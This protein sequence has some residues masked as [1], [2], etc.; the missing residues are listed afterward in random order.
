MSKWICSH[1]S[2]GKV[3]RQ[4]SL[5]VKEKGPQFNHF[6]HNLIQPLLNLEQISIWHVQYH[7]LH[8]IHFLFYSGV[9]ES[10][11][12]TRWKLPKDHVLPGSP[13]PDLHAAEDAEHRSSHGRKPQR[14][15]PRPVQIPQRDEGPAGLP[16]LQIRHVLP[17]ELRKKK[18]LIS[19][20]LSLLLLTKSLL[21]I[22]LGCSE[23]VQKKLCSFESQRQILNLELK[24]KIFI[25][26]QS[27]QTQAL[28]V[29]FSCLTFL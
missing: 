20:L 6:L 10:E 16:D 2:K 13:L 28:Y 22:Y 12:E 18:D 26:H 24:Y 14:P 23:H 27:L 8:L 29:F 17:K 5:K 21:L 7:L 9:E 3:K 15:A 1:T 11:A 4:N 19:L 25:L